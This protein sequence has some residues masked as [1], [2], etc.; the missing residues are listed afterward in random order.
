MQVH[1]LKPKKNNNKKKKRIGRGGKRGSF[2]GKGT[3]GQKK[4][5]GG[6]TP[7]YTKEL[8]KK[9]P[10]LR[11]VKN[12]SV[13]ADKVVI[14]IGELNDKFESGDTVNKKVL[15]EKGLIDRKSKRIKIL[16]DG[17]IDVDLKIENIPTSGSAKEKIENAGGS[18]KQS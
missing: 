7:S 15:R 2:S 5:A 3:K 6:T 4:R 10:K 11:G 12:K 8:I 1:D 17:D 14:N 16:G 13:Q 9:F 18:V